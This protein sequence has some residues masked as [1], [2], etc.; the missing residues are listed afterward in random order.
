VARSAYKAEWEGKLPV[1]AICD[2]PGQGER[3][4]FHM[5]GGVKVWLCAAHRSP[6][7]LTR[8]AGRDLAA[9]LLRIW[10]ATGS[11]NARR[12]AAVGAHLQ[13]VGEARRRAR[14]GSYAWPDLRDEAERRF[15]RGEP[16]RSVISEL[17][18]A[19]SG[20]RARVP[21]V[22]TMQRWFADGRWLGEP[23]S[24]ARAAPDTA[25]PTSPAP[26]GDGR[27]ASDPPGDAR[28]ARLPMA[29]GPRG[30]TFRPP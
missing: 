16:P 19:H 23:A 10:R 22:R 11:L 18:R 21:S 17:R 13:R 6:E 29:R 27:A 5:T 4:L 25:P 24:G 12:S 2:G 3:A 8:R 7:F 1:C 28:S 9:S 15:A 20:D 26:H 14:P 30:P